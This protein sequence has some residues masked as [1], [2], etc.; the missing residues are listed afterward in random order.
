MN[1]VEATLLQM[2]AKERIDVK[3]TM[4]V[5]HEY[6]LLWM[7]YITNSEMYKVVD[8]KPR[9]DNLKKMLLD[10]FDCEDM[11]EFMTCLDEM[12]FTSNNEK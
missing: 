4:N 10:T 9:I 2:D 3:L 6:T 11:I 1:K 8:I 5:I 12:K 7:D